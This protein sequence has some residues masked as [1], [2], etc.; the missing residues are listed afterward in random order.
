[1]TLETR[2]V[3]V[4]TDPLAERYRPYL[5]WVDDSPRVAYI[6]SR[7]TPIAPMRL[8]VSL[9]GIGAGYRT[10]DFGDFMIFY[11]FLPPSDDPLASLPSAGWRATADPPGSDPARA[12]DRDAD[13][14]WLSEAFIRP[15]MWYRLDLG[16]IATVA[17]LGVLPVRPQTGIPGGYVIEVSRDGTTWEAAS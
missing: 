7:R 4:A 12:F 3:I 8:A 14:A 11:D 16:T 5:R 9:R 15:G 13:T 2:E 6:A 17:E 10:G 1:M